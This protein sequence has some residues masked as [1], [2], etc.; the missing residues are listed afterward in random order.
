MGQ[1]TFSD[2]YYKNELS[3]YT[4]E[5][6][7]KVKGGKLGIPE[8]V[9]ISQELTD[10]YVKQVGE[11]PDNA[12]LERLSTILLHEELTDPNVYKMTNVEY[13]I[14]SEQQEAR[15]KERRHSQAGAIG[16][17][18]PLTWADEV[19]SDGID[20]RPKTRDNNRRLRDAL[21]LNPSRK[22]AL[23]R[24]RERRKAYREFTKQQPVISYHVSQLP[25]DSQL[26]LSPYFPTK[27]AEEGTKD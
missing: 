17:E 27:L 23:V 11:V 4:D 14:L 20:N 25:K 24:N 16:G 8:A 18:V 22:Y 21:R 10:A 6:H 12:A 2:G 1:F 26:R 9:R 3:R 19:G 7:S 15:R 5:L 13:P